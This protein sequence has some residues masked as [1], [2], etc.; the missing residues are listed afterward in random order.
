MR[1]PQRQRSLALAA[2]LVLAAIP[3]GGAQGQGVALQVGRLF[4]DGGWTAYNLSWTRAAIGPFSWQAG[5]QLLQG[6]AAAGRSHE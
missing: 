5:G 6:P 1:R 4:D 3:G 2:S